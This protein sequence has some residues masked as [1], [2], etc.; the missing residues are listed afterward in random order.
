MANEG[1]GG[2]GEIKMG[3]GGVLLHALRGID[4]S[5]AAEARPSGTPVYQ[6]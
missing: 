4:A 2:M 5:D 1:R 6:L 3:R